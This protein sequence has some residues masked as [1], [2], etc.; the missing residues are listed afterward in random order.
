MAEATPSTTPSRSVLYALGR[1][2]AQVEA[3]AQTIKE[4]PSQVVALF[5]PQ[6]ALIQDHET[7]IRSLERGR[8][9]LIGGGGLAVTAIGWLISIAK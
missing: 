7:R 6:L 2:E 4:L 5:A 1:L 9:V 3:Q 8:W